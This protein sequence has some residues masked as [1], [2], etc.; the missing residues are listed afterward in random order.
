[1]KESEELLTHW[2]FFQTERRLVAQSPCLSLFIARK[3]AGRGCTLPGAG[4][5]APDPLHRAV[6]RGHGR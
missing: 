5:E 4:N 2:V 6:L 1:M 3:Q